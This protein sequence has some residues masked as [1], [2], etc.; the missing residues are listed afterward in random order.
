[1]DFVVFVVFLL[2]FLLESGLMYCQIVNVEDPI[3]NAISVRIPKL[4]FEV[5]RIL[6]LVRYDV[7]VAIGLV[8]VQIEKNATDIIIGLHCRSY[9]VDSFY[10]ASGV[11]FEI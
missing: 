7:N 3:I 5:R 10:G 1:M 4:K 2:E 8:N 9:I 11:I 6:M